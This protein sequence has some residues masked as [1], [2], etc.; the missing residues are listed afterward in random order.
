LTRPVAERF[1]DVFGDVLFNV[2]GSTE[3]S[4]ATIATPADL[5]AV[6]GTAG[7]PPLGTR[8]RLLGDDDRPVPA[9]A[10]GRIFVGNELLFEGYTDGAGRERH[11][12]LMATGDHGYLD[13][14]GS[15]WS[16]GTT[17]W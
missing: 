6:A 12:G 17:T 8:V 13:R 15:S 4:W 2:Y 16:A 14:A 7:R 11:N 1:Q 3:I 10:I 5:R 9:G